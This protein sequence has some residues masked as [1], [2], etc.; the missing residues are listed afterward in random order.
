MT[1]A[2]PPIGMALGHVDF[3]DQRASLMGGNHYPRAALLESLVR[4]VLED[5]EK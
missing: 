1:W 2:M 4:F 3:K 5:L